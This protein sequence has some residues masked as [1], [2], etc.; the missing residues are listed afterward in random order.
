M[1]CSLKLKTKQVYDIADCGPNK[2]YA[3]NGKVVH[4]SSRAIQLQ[5]MKRDVMDDPDPVIL[6]II[7]GYEIDK[8]AATMGRL[9]RAAITHPDGLTWSDYSQ[10]E[11][12]VLPWLSSDPLAEKTLDIFR[13]GRDIYKENAVGMFHLPPGSEIDKDMRQSAKMGVLAAGFGG[14]IG[15]IQAMAKAYGL[16]YSD[17]EADDI[18]HNWRKANPWAEPFWYA[19]K[20]AAQRAVRIPG[21]V[22]T[23]GRLSFYSDGE[24]W[25]WMMLPSGRCLAYAKPYFEIVELPWGDKS[26]ELTCLWGSG[27]PKAGEKWPRRTLNHLILSE[28]ATQASAADIMRETIVR[29]HDWEIPTLFSVHDELVAQGHHH[30]KLHACMIEPPEWA[31]GLPIEAD[32]TT[33]PRYGK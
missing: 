29:A 15:A 18:K 1:V 30:E 4:N 23:A 6:D 11:A 20:D 22:S 21:I 28:N 14:G 16:K 19:L 33:G 9:I 8:P 32:T 2:R 27:K 10:I 25:L 5:N 3:I 17:D 7:E 26:L 31:E 12:R 13:E 24:S